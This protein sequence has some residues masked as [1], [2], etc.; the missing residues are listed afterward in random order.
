MTIVRQAVPLS[1]CW[2]MVEQIFTC[3]PW[4]TPCGAIGCLKKAVTLWE[5]CEGTGPGRTCGPMEKGVHTGAGCWQGPTLGECVS[6]GLHPNE[7][8]HT[9]AI[10]EELLPLGRTQVGEVHGGLFSVGETPHW[11]K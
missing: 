2:P 6:A 11:R 1:P 9:G 5:A 3:N 4:R 10:C 8:D 7:K